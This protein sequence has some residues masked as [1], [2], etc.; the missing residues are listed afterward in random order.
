MTLLAAAMLACLPLAVQAQGQSQVSGLPEDGGNGKLLVEGLCTFCHRPNLIIS[1]SGYT[2][3]G[4]QELVATMLD[5]SNSPQERTA[6]TDYLAK[7]FPPNTK[8]APKLVS[9]PVEIA[10]T[11]WVM[12]TLGQRTRDPI[13]AADGT[14]WW[15][16]QFGNLIGHFNPKT[17]AMREYQLPDMSK[18]HTIELDN[19]GT[20]W[21]TGNMNGSVGKVDPVTG[22]VT[23]YKM[24]DPAAKDPHTIKFDKHNIMWFSLQNSDMIGRLDPKSGDI[25]LVKTT[26]GSKPYGVK[27]DAQGNPW[28]S[29][30][31]RACLIKVD[32]ATMALTEIALPEGSTVR[33]LDI[34]EDGMV[35]YVNSSLGRLGRYN[36]KSG[37]I[38]EW[39]SPSGAKSHP[40]AIVIVDGVV[41]YNESFQRP[42]ALVRFDP[43]TETFQSWAIPSGGIHA[44]H[45]RHMNGTK[46]GNLLIHQSS[47]NRII[48]VTA[49]RRAA[50]AR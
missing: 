28:I 29:C 23:V 43:K 39:P 25:K 50:E 7:H 12:P 22:Q 32:P 15:A 34:A 44:G 40:Y 48:Q 21:Y 19:Q 24:P 16:G 35:W 3:E 26:R 47:S 6:L 49:K 42:D 30:N 14:I 31:G 17:G 41:W 8:R 11:E 1:S 13:Q 5:M 38:K 27:L 4:W 10:F 2:R 9:G 20:P 37:E 45:I 46:E 18:P 33:R 36:P